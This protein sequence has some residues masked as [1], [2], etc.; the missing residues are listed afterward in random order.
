MSEI[1]FLIFASLKRNKY[2]AGFV[3]EDIYCILENHTS[4]NNMCKLIILGR[5]LLRIVVFQIKLSNNFN[6]N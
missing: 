3:A 6:S 4:D 2:L 1:Y 5:K